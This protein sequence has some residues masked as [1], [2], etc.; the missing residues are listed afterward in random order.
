VRRIL[1]KLKRF[2]TKKAA[3]EYEKREYLLRYHLFACVSHSEAISTAL[4]VLGG[5]LEDLRTS[6]TKI[7][8]EKW[9]IDS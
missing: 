1:G 7:L 8:V 5:E 4:G 3:L 9:M 6:E 2:V